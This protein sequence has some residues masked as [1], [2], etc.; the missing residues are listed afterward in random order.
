[1][2]GS[3]EGK[4]MSAAEV[5]TP[6]DTAL[7]YLAEKGKLNEANTKVLVIEPMLRAL[8]CNINSLLSVEREYQVYAGT[9]LDFALKAPHLALFVEARLKAKPRRS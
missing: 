6:I 8:G 3:I 4:R 5:S 1:M 9:F 7:E 2:A